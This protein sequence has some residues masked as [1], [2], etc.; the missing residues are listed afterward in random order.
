MP[1]SSPDALP[2][3]VVFDLDGTLAE[4][5]GDL[6]GTLNVI[7]ERE[8]LPPVAVSQARELIGAGARALIQRGFAAGGR[9]LMP[10]RLD[11]LF[12]VFLAHYGENLCNVSH[13]FPGVVDSLDRLEE[14]GYRLAVCTNK[15]EDHSVRLLELL[16]VKARFAAICGRDTFPYFKPDPRH[17]TET[18]AQAGG[19]PARAV[20][21]GD[22]RTDVA[23][24]K[25]AGIPVV[26]VP[27][28]YTDVPVEELEP[29]VVIQ[30]FDALYEA[31]RRL[32][33]GVD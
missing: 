13:L 31:V 24:A 18:I 26:A 7:L 3:I 32:D 33:R 23:T 22:S 21:V 6:I 15:P 29:D 16:G 1:T 25:A 9:E 12:R 8:E 30:H 28:G 17:L 27:F 14:A 4:T 5:A 11:A 2:P 10:D 20:M 19:D